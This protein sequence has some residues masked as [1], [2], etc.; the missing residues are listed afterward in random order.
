[1]RSAF[2]WVLVLPEE[3]PDMRATVEAGLS[4]LEQQF[5]PRPDDAWLLVPADHPTLN[6]GRVR[7]VPEARGAAPAAAPPPTPSGAAAAPAAAR[8]EAVYRAPR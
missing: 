2:A 5:H 4:W 8:S 3:T 7:C 1:M 6:A